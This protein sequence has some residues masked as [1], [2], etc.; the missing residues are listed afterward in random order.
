MNEPPW[1]EIDPEMW[2]LLRAL[3]RIPGIA[4]TGCC[5]GHDAP[6]RGV[7]W[8]RPDMAYVTLTVEG[9]E[10]LDALRRRLPHGLQL[11]VEQ[12]GFKP[13]SFNMVWRGPTL[14]KRVDYMREIVRS[15]GADDQAAG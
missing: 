4:T 9:L 14:A 7:H 3:N 6:I 15:L 13:L 11:H 12:W 8:P 5:I 1:D 2:P 10:A